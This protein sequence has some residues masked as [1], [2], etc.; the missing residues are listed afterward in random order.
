MNFL[1]WNLGRRDLANQVA[2]LMK[3]R[4]IHVAMLAE[5]GEEPSGFIRE[6]NLASGFAHS[7]ISTE[8][9]RVLVLSRFP[10]IGLLPKRDDRRLSIYEVKPT[11][12]PAFLLAVAHL[13]SR[14]HW[15]KMDLSMGA[16]SYAETV[17][18]VESECGHER[19]VLVGDLNL[20]PFEDGI[21]GASG[22]HAVADRTV[23]EKK[24]RIVD[25]ARY[26][27]FYNPMWNFFGD[28]SGNAK[29]TYFYRGST[30]T[31]HFWHLFDQ[32]LIRP[33]LLGCWQADE[34]EIVT[35]INGQGIANLDGAPDSGLAS[36]HFPII[37]S[38]QMQ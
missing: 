23:A 35:A 37:F 20:N 13:P 3:D 7:R 19:T 29:G 6:L 22:F 38:M 26:P 30:L 8:A 11:A 27:F 31:E 33:S 9:A 25:G 34:L 32:V 36:D 17:R 28:R 1:F 18:E 4:D 5:V 15:D 12:D 10:G 21:V 16:I 24:A 14:L 2:A